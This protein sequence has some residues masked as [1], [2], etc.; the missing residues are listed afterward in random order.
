MKHRHRTQ[1]DGLEP[2]QPR[3]HHKCHH[4]PTAFPS[5]VP[6]QGTSA[7]APTIP[8]HFWGGGQL[9]KTTVLSPYLLQASWASAPAGLGLDHI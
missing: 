9:R 5:P 4:L 8:L 2:L 7:V 6:V 1:A 3:S